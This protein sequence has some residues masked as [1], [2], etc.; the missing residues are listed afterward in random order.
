MRFCNQLYRA[1]YETEMTHQRRDL[2][3]KNYVDPDCSDRELFES[4]DMGDVWIDANLAK[5]YFYLRENT[6]LEIPESW[7]MTI[8]NF[9]MELFAAVPHWQSQLNSARIES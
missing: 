3:R 8:A 6:H 9:D 1:F 4:L 5:T 7:K 2:R